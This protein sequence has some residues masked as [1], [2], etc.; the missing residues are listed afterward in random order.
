MSATNGAFRD[1]FFP[2]PLFFGAEDVLNSD[3]TLSHLFS[4]SSM[5]AVHLGTF[6]SLER[7]AGRVSPIPGFLFLFWILVVVFPPW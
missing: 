4:Q 7:I 6:G 1:T 2:L 5:V 3:H